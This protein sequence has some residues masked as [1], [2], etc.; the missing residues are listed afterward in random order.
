MGKKFK[1]LPKRIAGYKI[2]KRVRKNSKPLLQ[3]LNTPQFR[4]LIAA[5]VGAGAAALAGHD[6]SD[7][8]KSGA[9][10]AKRR[11]KFLAEE[12]KDRATELAE[13]V[14]KA[15][16]GAI[17]ARLPTVKHSDKNALKTAH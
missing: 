15:V 2:P 14:G 3:L 17:S 4:G 5:A 12:G 9:K 8:R 13:T 7:E 1:K 10:K 11:F 6:H 16:A